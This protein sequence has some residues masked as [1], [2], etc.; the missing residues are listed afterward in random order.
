MR[1]L[2]LL[3][4]NLNR[5][6]VIQIKRNQR[7]TGNLAGFDEH[8][9]I[10]IENVKSEYYIEEEKENPDDDD[11]D[12]DE[13]DLPASVLKKAESDYEENKE[14]A[15]KKYQEDIG[16]IILRGDN[17]IFMK[18][19]KPN[20]SRPQ[21]SPYYKKKR[22][23]GSRPQKD[24]HRDSSDSRRRSSGGYNRSNR[25]NRDSRGGYDN[26]KRS[27]DPRKN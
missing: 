9:N 7:F 23:Q 27:R 14:Y 26:Q 16:S 1:P 12:D 8:L 11:D 5:E 24:Y 17:I 20:F 15:L 13:I 10:Y 3:S 4:L 2:D 21:K 22:Y 6:I 18:F 25:D 19:K